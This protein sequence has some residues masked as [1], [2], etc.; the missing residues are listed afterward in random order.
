[1]KMFFHKENAKTWIVFVVTL[2]TAIFMC[3]RLPEQI[4]M[5]FNAAGVADGYGNRG[6]IFL[7]A[8]IILIMIFV[9]EISKKVDPESKQYS[10][11]GKQYY[12]IYFYVSLLL[13]AIQIY[14][15]AISLNNQ[16]GNLSVYMSVLIG[17]GIYESV[18]AAC[19]QMIQTDKECAPIAENTAKY[20][21]FHKLYKKLYNDLK[22][23]Y[24]T[25]ASL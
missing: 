19:D 24:K 3:P 25:L 7:F 13:F 17:A 11:F 4:P 6:T 8:G 5:H 22:D 2:L 15:I 20:N 14:V 21:E 18:E 12:Q 23:D 10:K 9:A 16:V 1:M